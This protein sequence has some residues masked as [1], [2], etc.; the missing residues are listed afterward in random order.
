MLPGKIES[1]FCSLVEIEAE[2]SPRIVELRASRA[3]NYLSREQP[4]LASQNLYYTNYLQRRNNKEEIYF[5]ILQC[6]KQ[7]TPC[8]LVRITK[9]ECN[10]RFSWE[11]LVVEPGTSPLVTIDAIVTIY[12]I[13]FVTLGKQL[14]GPWRVLKAGLRVKALH[15]YMG[16]SNLIGDDAEYFTFLVTKS[17]FDKKISYFNKQGFGRSTNPGFWGF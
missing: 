5:K 4:S 12:S 7:D 6:D 13:G 17:K 15:E 1:G 9:L 2:D 11:S 8:G 16:M 14:C 10:E 3:D